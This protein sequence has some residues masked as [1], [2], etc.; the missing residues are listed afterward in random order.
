MNQQPRA[1]GASKQ[2]RGA[3]PRQDFWCQDCGG[4]FRTA[5]SSHAVR[6]PE[7]RKLNNRERARLGMRLNRSRRLG[8]E[9]P[10]SEAG[11]PRSNALKTIR[12]YCGHM[13]AF[14]MM[15][16]PEELLWC[17]R[18]EDWVAQAKQCANKKHWLT[19]HNTFIDPNSGKELCHECCFPEGG[20]DAQLVPATQV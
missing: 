11:T 2:K 19:R 15:P 16:M 9:K 7:C 4:I 8:R 17:E 10:A 12:L 14:R 20:Q 5:R 13:T 1:G 6:C 3:P 18:C